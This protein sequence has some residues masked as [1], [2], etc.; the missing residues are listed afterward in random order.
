MKQF[1]IAVTAFCF[2]GLAIADGHGNKISFEQRHEGTPMEVTSVHLNAGGGTI[3]A[4]GQMGTYGRTYVTYKLTARPD[5][6]SG[7]VDVE[8]RGAM[9]DGAFASGAGVGIYSRNGTTFTIHFLVNMQDGTQNLDE[10]VFDA[11][12]R[13][14]THDVY[15]VQ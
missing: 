14:L 10:V 15:I 4:E 12:T 7:W 13:E 1:L 3:T 9:A 8:G 2:A 11:Y 6:K 5:G